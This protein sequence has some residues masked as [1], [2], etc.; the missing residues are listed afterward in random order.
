MIDVLQLSEKS[1][2]RTHQIA[3]RL[4]KELVEAHNITWQEYQHQIMARELERVDTAPVK[5][6]PSD[7]DLTPYVDYQ[8]YKLIETMKASMV[9]PLWQLKEKQK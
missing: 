1:Y 9:T 7:L 8:D 2:L 4:E 3:Q 6:V 5:T